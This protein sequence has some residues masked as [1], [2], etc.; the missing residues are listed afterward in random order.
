[1]A[2]IDESIVMQLLLSE[3]SAALPSFC[4]LLMPNE[5]D[6]EQESDETGGLTKCLVRLSGVDH[7]SVA[8]P[9]DDGGKNTAIDRI[10]ASI[11]ISVPGERSA[12]SAGVLT[13]VRSLVRKA[14]QNLRVRDAATGHVLHVQ[15]CQS[16]SDPNAA[17]GGARAFEIGMVT[18][19][20]L[21][22]RPWAA[23]GASETIGSYTA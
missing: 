1:M 19:T 20:G 12:A 23:A 6:P 7:Q 8:T 10:T 18:A 21:V 14:L 4:V 22:M 2:V 17:A 3:L 16:A 9:R 13:Q 11:V 15:A 5:P